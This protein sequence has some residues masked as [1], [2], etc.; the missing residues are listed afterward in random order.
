M[1]THTEGNITF[2]PP[3]FYIMDL[4]G[5]TQRYCE[6]YSRLLPVVAMSVKVIGKYSGAVFEW[7]LNPHSQ[8]FSFSLHE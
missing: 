1:H 4:T 2:L 6:I 3:P 7:D 5:D 8:F